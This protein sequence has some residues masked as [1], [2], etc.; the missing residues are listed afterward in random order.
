MRVKLPACAALTVVVLAVTA[1]VAEASPPDAGAAASCGQLARGLIKLT[2][3]YSETPDGF[4]KFVEPWDPLCHDFTGDGRRDVAFAILSGGTGGAFKFAVFRRSSKRGGSLH[5]RYVKMIERGHGSKTG[6]QR[7]GRRLEVINPIY[8][9]GDGN[10]CPSGG[11]YVRTYRFTR[12]KAIYVGR[13][14]VESR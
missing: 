14:K 2:R 12:T 10:C 7:N 13:R 11:T 3:I 4:R 8:R 5:R 1:P 6:L 9:A